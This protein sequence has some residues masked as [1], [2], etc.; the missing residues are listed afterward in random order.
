MDLILVKLLLTPTLIACVS[1]AQRRWGP[2]VGGLLVGL[3]LTSAPLLLVL[4]LE[5][6][7]HFAA[8]A[9][10]AAL[11]GQA[12]VALFCFGYAQAAMRHRRQ[13]CITA[14]AGCYLISALVA[15]G[16][17]ISVQLLGILV[18]TVVA[19]VVSYWPVPAERPVRVV[20]PPAWEVPMRMLVSVVSTLGLAGAASLLGPA[21][22]GLLAAFP[23]FVCILVLRTHRSAGDPATIAFLRGTVQSVWSGTAFFLTVALTITT[24]GTAVAFAAAL[25]AAA[26]V[27]A[28]TGLLRK[29]SAA[30]FTVREQATLNRG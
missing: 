9:A 14:A 23:V 29:Q 18:V 16:L 20:P 19:V 25:G 7:P 6:G 28:G 15:D 5:R 17:R 8:Q 10:T 1:L 21:R 11:F 24:M 4:S 3:P 30:R 26:L 12:C 2:I 13:R 22:A 27:A